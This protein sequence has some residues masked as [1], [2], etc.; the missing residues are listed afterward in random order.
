MLT[1]NGQFN[2]NPS[3]V[4]GDKSI[5]HRALILASIANGKSVI[6][7]LPYSRDVMAT[8]DCLRTLGAKIVLDDNTATV[9]PI[10]DVKN[11][12]TLN[13]LPQDCLRD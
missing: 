12:V 13:C 2:I 4:R 11:N 1:L 9:E 8:V 6:K 7:N 10:K 3:V 5:S